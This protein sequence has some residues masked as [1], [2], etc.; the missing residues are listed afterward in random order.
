MVIC[1]QIFHNCSRLSA[2]PS[3]DSS[4]APVRL[5]LVTRAESLDYLRTGHHQGNAGSQGDQPQV[6]RRLGNQDCRRHSHK[7]QTQHATPRER[8]K[9]AVGHEGRRRKG[10]VP[11]PER[12]FTQTQ[13]KREAHTGDKADS[14]R[15]VV[16]NN[17]N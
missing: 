13:E 7:N 2:E 5:V 10:Q 14:Q 6:L 11:P 16:R 4:E 9:Y 17:L 12:G 3:T 1:R 15:I 8:E